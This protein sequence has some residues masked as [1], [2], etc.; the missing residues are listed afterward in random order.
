MRREKYELLVYSPRILT[1]TKHDK[2]YE[3]YEELLIDMPLEY[4]GPVI[5]LLKTRRADLIDL[6]INHHQHQCQAVFQLPTTALI[7]LN[8]ELATLTRGLAVLNYFF[9]EMRGRTANY[10]PQ[11]RGKLVANDSGKA[12]LYALN[13]ISPRGILFVSPGQT[14]Y[15]GMI[16]GERTDGQKHTDLD[17]NPTKTK[18]ETNIRAAAKDEKMYL[19]PKK[20]MTIEEMIAYMDVDEVVEISPHAIRLRKR[21]MDANLRAKLAREHKKKR[22][23][24]KDISKKKQ[25]G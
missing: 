4:Q 8:M 10:T 25:K 15:P 18:K 24:V 5:D 9:L 3:P 12:S 2:I 23:N 14:V 13:Q 1:I 22:L 21:E 6:K 17:V 20:H 16:I 7:G 19:P 11:K